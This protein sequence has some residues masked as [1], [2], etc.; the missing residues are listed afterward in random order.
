MRDIRSD[1][2]ERAGVIGEQIRTAQVQFDKFVEQLT[3]EHNTRL[4]D[5]RS[6]LEAVKTLINIEHRRHSGSQSAPQP[7]AQGPQ[8]PMSR[9]TFARVAAGE[10]VGLR[11]AV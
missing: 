1:L 2:Q 11:R 5:L 4:Q 10:A 7:Q 3:D 9:E 8:P 6:E